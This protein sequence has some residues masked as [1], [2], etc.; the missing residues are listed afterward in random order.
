M[1]SIKNLKEISIVKCLFLAILGT[2]ILALSAKIKIPFWPVPMTMQTFVVLLLG[3][4][5]GWKLGL[6][7]VSLYLLEGIAGLPVFAGSPE[8]G[9]GLVY[10]TGHT[11]GYLIGFLVAVFLTGFLTFNNNFFNNFIKLVFSVSFIYLL[12]LIWL[13]SLI[14]WDKPVFELGAKPF[15]LAE[16]FKIGL[17]VLISKKIFKFRKLI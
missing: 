15:L 4:V 3:I 9:V 2:I 10:F 14:G 1:E 8:K 17:V 11:M 12:G 6:F 7:T 16:I 13:G 5:Y